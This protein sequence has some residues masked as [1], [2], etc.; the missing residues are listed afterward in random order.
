MLTQNYIVAGRPAFSHPS[1]TAGDIRYQAYRLAEGVRDGE[2]S[3]MQSFADY[4]TDEGVMGCQAELDLDMTF[5]QWIEQYI[6]TP[7]G[8]SWLKAWAHEEAAGELDE[9]GVLT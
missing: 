7:L 1:A 9:Y 8:H 6:R 3:L 5:R 2:E 4:L